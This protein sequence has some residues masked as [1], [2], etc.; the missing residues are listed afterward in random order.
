MSPEQFVGLYLCSTS[1]WRKLPIFSNLDSEYVD[2]LILAVELNHILLERKGKE[3]YKINCLI[4][5]RPRTG[6]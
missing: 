2:Y 5:K 3:C 4:L 6:K 1:N